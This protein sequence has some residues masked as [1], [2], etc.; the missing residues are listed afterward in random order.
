ME[1]TIEQIINQYPK[2]DDCEFQTLGELREWQITELKK[3]EQVFIDE[4]EKITKKVD[5]IS[6]KLSR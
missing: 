1:L 2:T 4:I 6:K 3:R 5:E